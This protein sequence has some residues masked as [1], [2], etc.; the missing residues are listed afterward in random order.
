M[1][2]KETTVAAKTND[3][4]ERVLGLGSLV[5]IACGTVISSAVF[6]LTGPVTA[7][8]GRGTWIAFLVAV[9]LGYFTVLPYQLLT[10][11]TRLP[12]GD[13][14]NVAMFV[15]KRAAGLFIYNFVMMNMAFAVSATSIG[16]YVTAI[17]PNAPGKLIGILVVTVFYFVNIC[18]LKFMSRI[19]NITFILLMLAFVAY[20]AF[21]LPK[22]LPG[23]F[24]I[25][26]EGYFPMGAKGFWSS[27]TALVFACSVYGTVGAMGM[28]AKDGRRDIPKAMWITA[29]VILVC[30]TLLSL[31]AS[32]TLPM[33]EVAGK[34]LVATA[35]QLLPKGL[36]VFFVICGPFL[37]VVT[38]LNAGYATSAK[39]Y[40]AAT[41]LGWFPKKFAWKNKYGQPVWCVLVI[42]LVTV[43]PVLLTN[44]VVTIA[45]STTLVQYICKLLMLLGC[46]RAPSVAPQL[47]ES[48]A[49]S[50][51]PKGIYYF[52]LA[53]C[54]AV[55][56]FLIIM[57][58]RSLT[59]FQVSVSVICMIILSIAATI[60]QATK[61]K[62]IKNIEIT[63]DLE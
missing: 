25:T 21:G 58:A 2:T 45:N 36:F 54:T 41:E 53:I 47:W 39:P 12:G 61:G 30:Y 49:L 48:S 40:A 56:I 19:Q 26:A 16:S 52:L 9:V 29:I 31:V 10:M 55:Q 34:N 22:L 32:N 14:S 18:P 38:T 20:L 11:I 59:R 27:V 4:P 42:Y 46:W 5:T 63:S 43:V 17:W 15:G 37:A 13:F 8:S 7:L 6:S 50:K 3:H 60:W 28:Q 23:T 62:D 24:N 33:S 44:N 51:M 57:A 1:A 35:S